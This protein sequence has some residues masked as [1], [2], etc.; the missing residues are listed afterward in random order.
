M[1]STTLLILATLLFFARPA[2]AIVT[3]DQEGSHAVV[4]GAITFG[5]NL[6]GVVSFELG[7]VITF[8]T[9]A[10]ISDR[11]ILTS[12]QVV[13]LDLDGQVDTGEDA[14]FTEVTFYLPGG[15]V[16][17]GVDTAMT[18]IPA[19]WTLRPGSDADL[20]IVTLTA[21]APAAAPRYRLYGETDEVG[22]PAVVVGAGPVGHGSMGTDIFSDD[23]AM[24]A[25]LN[26]I[27]ARGEDFDNLVYDT[28]PNY[29][30]VYDFDSGMAENN[31]LDLLGAPSD[32]GFGADEVG[33][34]VF[35]TGGPLFV[36]GAIAG[37]TALHLG[38]YDSDV[39]MD[40]ADASWGEIFINTRISSFQDFIEMATG[41][42]AVF[43]PRPGSWNVDVSGN[44]SVVDNWTD[45]VPNAVGAN[46]ILGSIITEP[47]TVTLDAPIT[48]GRLEIENSNA[49]TIAGQN[50]LTLDVTSGDAVIN[51]ANGSHTISAP[52]VLADNTVVTVTPGAGRLSLTGALTADGKSVTK[53]G[54][55]TLTLN[56]LRAAA[57]SV[58][59]GTVAI[60]ANGG[61][62]GASVLSA[63]SI[64]GATDAWTAKLD[65]ANNDAIVHSTAANKAADFGRLYNQLKQGFN[66]GAWTGL[67][68]TSATAAAN[69][70]ADT[71]LA[72]VD[73]ALLGLSNF[74]GQTVT[75]DSIV[76]K[77]TYYGDI[78]QNGQVDA[79]DLT[80]FAGNFGRTTGATQVDGDIDFNGRVD[81]D[82]LTVFANNFNKGV[83]GPLVA[84]S[85]QAVPEPGTWALLIVASVVISLREMK[86]VSSRRARGL[87]GYDQA[88]NCPNTKSYAARR[89]T[90]LAP[91]FEPETLTRSKP[92]A[93][94]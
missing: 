15:N 28:D 50:P 11:H 39:T 63:L 16:A 7:D 54:A 68:I 69:A 92:L 44:W 89:M 70:S 53:V 13:D 26:R 74:S 86:H 59:G 94:S 56:N 66:S 34:F 5:L 85:V 6:N 73:N 35:D 79:D 18:S 1:R 32:L 45:G 78:D 42:L 2:V 61:N 40:D 8:G 82:D 65:L 12:A 93:H 43:E 37:L 22:K 36:D 51:A 80:V 25:G 46:A 52:V 14:L 24:R 64:T 88:P 38:E 49:Y 76:L 77:Y 58:N 75:A 67:G 71:G 10:L 29:T 62:D 19:D 87:I 47:R 4:P 83:G 60:A 31:T 23:G 3:S 17:V 33:A 30:L 55:G 72:V 21:D 91:P 27:E 84:A 57:L 20:A 41:G 48:V 9:G 90:L 81:A